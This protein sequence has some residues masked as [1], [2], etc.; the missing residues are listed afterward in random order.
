M[1]VAGLIGGAAIGSAIAYL[2][3]KV[4]TGIFDPPP[5]A[6]SVP[7]SYLSF[8]VAMVLGVTIVVVVAVG[9]LVARSG[10]SEL[11]DL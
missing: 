10:P 11:R 8:L 5:A 2:L 3:V 1:V 7:W 4:L 9:R 6:A